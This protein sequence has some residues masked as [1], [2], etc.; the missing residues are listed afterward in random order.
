MGRSSADFQFLKQC[1]VL[2]GNAC[3][4]DLRMSLPNHKKL[5]ITAPVL[6]VAPSQALPTPLADSPTKMVHKCS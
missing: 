1:F 2:K 3:M 5:L 4:D 6:E